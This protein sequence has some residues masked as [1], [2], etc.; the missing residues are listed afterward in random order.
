[1]SDLTTL[2]IKELH[3]AYK[4]RK[5]SAVEVTSAYLERIDAVDSRVNAYLTVTADLAVQQAEE[6]DRRL[7]SG[8]QVAP[9]TGVPVG[10]KDLLCT[11]GVRTTCASR[12][13]EG[14]IPPYNATVIER[15]NCQGAVMLGKLNMD[16]FAMGSST[17]NS[18]FHCTHNPWDLTRVPGGSSG[19]SSA[20]VAA[21]LCAGSLGSDTGGSIRQPASYCGVVGLKPTY[22]RVSRFG[23]IAFAS[24]LDQVGPLTRDVTDC[25]LVMNAISGHDP[26]DSTSVASEAMDYTQYLQ[27]GLKGMRC[28]LPKE[29]FI[30]GVQKDVREAVERAIAA[31]KDMGCEIVPVSLPHTPYAVA[32][33]YIVATSEA[34]SNLS[35][36][37]GV[38]YG[39][40]ASDYA[41][42]IDMYKKT[43]STGF[44]PEVKRRIMLGSYSL[45]AGY[46]DAFYKKASQVRTLF[47]RDF[48][49]AFKACDVLITPVA[50]TTAFKL[51]EKTENPIQMYLNDIF[52]IPVNLAGIPALSMPC[53]FDG[54][55]LPIGVQIMADAFRED[56]LFRVAYNLEQSVGRIQ[57]WP[58][59]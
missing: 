33:Y 44:G 23:L 11:K 41:N 15:L 36:Y 37:D 10:I 28:G 4:A 34:S 20:A 55:G 43:R 57:N 46:Y 2:S 17:E 24:S 47:K 53:G 16:E 58:E 8:E 40:R 54:K 3:D 29:Y 31:L 52:T 22:G 59:L 7:Q 51:G 12:M 49:N 19:G 38:K 25:A 21:R 1:M 48:D 30:E 56:N 18:A 26:K 13:L 32:T 5:V 45:S 35:R 9:L 14:F 50:P 27:N 42:L 6:A 39:F